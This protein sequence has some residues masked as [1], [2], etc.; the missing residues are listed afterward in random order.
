[1]REPTMKT[2]PA[3]RLPILLAM[4]GVGAG[5]AAAQRRPEQPVAGK[6]D[7]KFDLVSSN[8]KDT[9]MNLDR[10]AIELGEPGKGRVDVTIAMVPNMSG[11]VSRGGKFKAEA[12]RG[13]T[14]IEGLEGRFSIAGR[15]EGRTVQFLFIAEYY[16]D[17]KALCTQSW[18]ASGSKP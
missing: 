16:K 18:N 14:A 10:T 15:V 9:G 11:V 3:L 6:F 7:A 2:S 17:G 8:C 4:L 1:M 12:K 13:R 5:S